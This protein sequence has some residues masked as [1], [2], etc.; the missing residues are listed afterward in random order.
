ME[1]KKKPRVNNPA[2][3]SKQKVARWLENECCLVSLGN[4]SNVSGKK[5]CHMTE[6]EMSYRCSR[7]APH[8]YSLL[9]RLIKAA[10]RKERQLSD[11]MHDT[12]SSTPTSTSTS[13]S[14]PA[15]S[16]R[17]P[18]PRR[19]WTPPGWDSSTSRQRSS[20]GG[21]TG[22]GAQATVAGA[23]ASTRLGGSVRQGGSRTTLVRAVRSVR[24]TGRGRGVAARPPHQGVYAQ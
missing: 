23:S 16:S 13:T 1:A 22:S 7:H 9:H 18:K 19:K 17:S 21:G 8:L 15:R 11:S 2:K 4:W 10:K 5:L 6:T 12:A 3:W 24:S 14:T 20:G